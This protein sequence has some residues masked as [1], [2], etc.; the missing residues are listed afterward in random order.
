MKLVVAIVHREDSSRLSAELVKGKFNLTILDSVGGFLREKNSILL[1]GLDD[2][3]VKELLN[4][5]KE[6]SETRKQVIS[7]APPVV[8]LGDFFISKPVEVEVGGAT[9]FVIDVEQF[10]KL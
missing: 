10:K 2:K 9:V 8:E 1:I 6:H 5:I 4:L 7:S 3:R